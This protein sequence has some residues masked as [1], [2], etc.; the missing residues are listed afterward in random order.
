MKAW[1]I[2]LS[3]VSIL[4]VLAAFSACT[5]AP[6]EGEGGDG[7]EMEEARTVTVYSGRNES[8]IGPILERFEETS[9]IEVEVRYGETAEMAATLMEEG[10]G[11]PAYVFISQDAAAL[12]AV[13]D[14]GLLAPLPETI[15][16]RI[17]SRFADA[18]DRWVGLSGRARTVV[19]NTE[20][21]TPDELPQSLSE[22]TDPKY[23]GTFGVA[24]LNGSL[25]AHLSVYRVVNGPEA[26]QELL[27]GMVANEPTDYP[28]NSA[29]VEAVIRGEVDWGLVNHYYLWRALDEQ[30]D[31]PAANFYMPGGDASGFVNVAGVGMLRD[32]EASRELIAFLL[33]DEAQEYFA[34]ETFEYPLVESVP[35]AEGLKPLAEL[36][37]PDV[38]F[39]RVSDELEETIAAIQ[40]SGLVR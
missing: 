3:L 16:S 9:G 35:T 2:V 24:P 8:L 13:A 21:I 17:P 6:P 1:K 31:A 19:Y 28:K 14:A 29:I 39:G 20:R 34:R 25:Q 18:Q 23:R 5:E 36:D 32:V 15:M 10:E 40:S 27:A 37:S 11:S 30:P 7:G 33:S 4:G 22:V 12:G 26:L 38:D